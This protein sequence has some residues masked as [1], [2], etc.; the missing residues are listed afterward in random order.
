V[1]KGKRKADRYNNEKTENRVWL[2]KK[3]KI[4]YP[5]VVI[6]EWSHIYVTRDGL[7]TL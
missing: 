4:L 1:S 3:R 7:F 6:R 2:E 5:V